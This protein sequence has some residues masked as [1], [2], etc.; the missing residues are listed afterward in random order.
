MNLR[1]CPSQLRG[2]AAKARATR[3]K[4][5]KQRQA[6]AVARICAK[7]NERR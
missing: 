1:V 5:E 7:R 4:G 3:N 2:N 6:G